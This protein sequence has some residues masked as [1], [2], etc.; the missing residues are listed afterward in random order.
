MD[1][2]RFGH[3]RRNPADQAAPSAVK[4]GRVL[5]VGTVEFG[6]HRGEMPAEG[7][8]RNIECRSEW[9]LAR[10]F[11]L[12]VIPFHTDQLP[13]RK[14][15]SGYLSSRAT[16][17]I[18]LPIATLGLILILQTTEGQRIGLA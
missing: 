3:N 14:P 16:L 2:I 12:C 17:P 8:A 1:T 10:V 5:N 6:E 18:A 15:R 7:I 11:Q 9:Q 13:Q 4:D